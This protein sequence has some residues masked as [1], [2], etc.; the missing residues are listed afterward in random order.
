VQDLVCTAGVAEEEDFVGATFNL[1]LA[2][3]GDDGVPISV[4]TQV[5]GSGALG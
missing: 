2:D 3:V 4:A 5:Y 1:P